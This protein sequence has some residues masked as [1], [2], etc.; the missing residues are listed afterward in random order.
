MGFAK[1]QTLDAQRRFA[2]FRYLRDS[3]GPPR[4]LFLLIDVSFATRILD[5]Q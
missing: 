1:R 4:P 3:L 2:S 5:F